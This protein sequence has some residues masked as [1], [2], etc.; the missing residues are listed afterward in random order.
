MISGPDLLEA[1]KAIELIPDALD[2]KKI[3][4]LFQMTS[5]YQVLAMLTHPAGRW[6]RKYPEIMEDLAE[7]ATA[8]ERAAYK[9][10]ELQ[11]GR[12]NE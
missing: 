7:R 5:K 12:P 8:V 6:V 2:Q 11:D 1:N 3:K 10:P 4:G 9:R